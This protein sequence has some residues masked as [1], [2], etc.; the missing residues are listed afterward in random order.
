MS[1][2]YALILLFFIISL[3]ASFNIIKF[4]S[5]NGDWA[6][7]SICGIL[8]FYTMPSYLYPFLTL[9][10]IIFIY[11]YKKIKQQFVFNFFVGFFT[12]IL[13][14][15]IILHQG[16]EV[17]TSPLKDRMWVISYLP[18][19]FK[20]TLY[21]IFGIHLIFTIIPAIIAFLV[22]AKERRSFII[23]LWLIFGL[24]PVI[25]LIA[26]SVIPFPRTFIY[27]GFSIVF[28]IGLSLSKYIDK[29]PVNLLMIG[30]LVIQ[31]ASF[32][33]FKADINNYESFN[34]DY[35]DMS[36]KVIDKDSKGYVLS[37]L[38][39]DTHKFEMISKGYN[40]GNIKY[41]RLFYSFDEIKKVNIDTIKNID[42]YDYVVIDK[43]KDLTVHHKPSYSNAYLNLYKKE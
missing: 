9:N 43:D 1:R 28:L 10:L 33:N 37:G 13:Y 35:K 24:S 31:F 2:G 7:F 15:P 14:S 41:D 39:Y 21:E 34:I 36:D 38:Y 29:V 30:I 26:H 17:L 11:N 6:I 19:F 12:L 3:Y 16:F 40:P 32:L 22:A 20:N 18:L 4:G 8:G 25:L 27:C 5:R 42:S 23:I